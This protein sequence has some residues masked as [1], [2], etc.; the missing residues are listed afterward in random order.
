MANKKLAEKYADAPCPGCGGSLDYD[1]DVVF[2]TDRD[3][4]GW[5]RTVGQIVKGRLLPSPSAK[6]GKDSKKNEDADDHV[7]VVD[8]EEEEAPDPAEEPEESVE[9]EPA[10]EEEEPGDSV[11]E[12]EHV[13]PKRTPHE[14]D[15]IARRLSSY[16]PRTIEKVCKAAILIRQAVDMLS[17]AKGE[18]I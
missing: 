3:D 13:K 11:E 8:E 16:D 9:E 12:V 17:S 2:C 15:V 5:S 18:I 1:E 7:R 14:L 6:P 4:C 10:E